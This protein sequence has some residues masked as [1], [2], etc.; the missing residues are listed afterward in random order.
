MEKRKIKKINITLTYLPNSSQTNHLAN[1]KQTN[2]K[3]VT[4]KPNN[5]FI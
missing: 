2:E 3:S 5:D 4:L 1:N